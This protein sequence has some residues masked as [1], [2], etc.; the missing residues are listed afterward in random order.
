MYIMCLSLS[1]VDIGMKKCPDVQNKNLYLTKCG[2]VFWQLI[3]EFF[4]GQHSQKKYLVQEYHQRRHLYHYFPVDSSLIH[5]SHIL[6]L[7]K[8]LLVLIKKICNLIL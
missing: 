6:V 2:A 4:M 8:I 1:F 3:L 5:F 7:E